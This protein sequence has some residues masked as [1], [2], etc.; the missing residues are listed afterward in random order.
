[1]VDIRQYHE[2]DRVKVTHLTGRRPHL[3]VSFTGIGKPETQAQKEE[4]VTLG[5]RGGRNH[6]LFVA[7]TARGWYNDPATHDEIIRTVH[8]YQK[9]NRIERTSV[10]GNSMGG[11]GALIFA[12]SLGAQSCLALSAQ[13]SADPR[14]V[15]EE[16]R[17]SDYRNRIT[18]FTR[19][20]LADCLS[21]DCTY[22]VLHGA[23]GKERPHWSRFPRR[24]NLH[25]YVVPDVG[26]A[27]GRKLKAH[28]L[29][30]PVARCALVSRS[31]AFR[32]ALAPL[33]AR[34]VHAAGVGA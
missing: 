10:F 6:V 3:V 33:D 22:F 32:R 14:Q 4:F 5:H 24:G 19:P 15:P 30:E 23:A 16:T 17:W 7:D 11:Y 12:A 26:H 9:A 31:A 20:P 21:P 34:P 25:H 8:A 13:Y 1:M 18:E 28:K 2:S 27:V 29:L